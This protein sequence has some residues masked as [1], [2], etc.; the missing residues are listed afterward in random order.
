MINPSLSLK[1]HPTGWKYAVR[2]AMLKRDRLAKVAA[3]KRLYVA[4]KAHC[5]VR[6]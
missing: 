5:L 4:A 1:E 2:N 3:K 6:I